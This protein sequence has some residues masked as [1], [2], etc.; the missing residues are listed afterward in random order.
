MAIK[1]MFKG[2]EV[3]VG[4]INLHLAFVTIVSPDGEVECKRVTP[5]ENGRLSTGAEIRR[6]EYFLIQQKLNKTSAL[7]SKG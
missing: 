7:S 6:R 2:W 3:H 5:S 4:F 1:S